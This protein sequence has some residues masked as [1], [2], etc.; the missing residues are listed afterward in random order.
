[1][2]N[3]R[4]IPINP[5][6]DLNTVINQATLNLQSQ[7][8][9]VRAQMHNPTTASMTVSKDR[10]GVKDVAGLGIECRVNLAV[11]TAGQLS[12]TIDSE[13]TNK[14]IALCVGWILCWVPFITGIVGAINQS[15]LPEKIYT[16]LSTGSA[17]FGQQPFNN[18]Q[19]PVNNYQ[20]PV[21]NYQPPVNNYQAPVN[22]YQAPV[23]QQAPVN[24]PTDNN[25]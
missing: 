17:G 16:A 9:T 12:V 24:Q 18:Y 5:E 25:F 21:N 22:N 1:M 11:L 2:A 8:Y 10:D 3:N 14:I 6:S 13:W 4:I 20:A 15:G 7:G 23:D 19:P